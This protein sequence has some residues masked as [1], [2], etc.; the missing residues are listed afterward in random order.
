MGKTSRPKDASQIQLSSSKI[1]KTNTKRP[2]ENGGRAAPAAAVVKT[3]VAAAAAAKDEIDAIFA[4]AKRKAK[5]KQL[6][7]NA[8]KTQLKQAA[9]AAGSAAAQQD[10]ELAQLAGAV[11]GARHQVRGAQSTC[12]LCTVFIINMM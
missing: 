4:G 12:A 5:E 1:M 9:G 7:M 6:Q 8:Q 3:T 2:S 10:A 11:D